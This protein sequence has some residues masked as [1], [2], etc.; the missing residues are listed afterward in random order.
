MKGRGERSSSVGGAS[1][2]LPDSERNYNSHDPLCTTAAARCARN[3]DP[4]LCGFCRI[5]GLSAL[6]PVHETPDRRSPEPQIWTR[7]SG[8]FRNVWTRA[9]EPGTI[10]GTKQESE[11]RT[12]SRSASTWS[13]SHWFWRIGSGGS[14]LQTSNPEKFRSASCD[15]SFK[16]S[17]NGRPAR[18]CRNPVGSVSS[19]TRSDD[20]I[21][22]EEYFPTAWCRHHRVSPRLCRSVGVLGDQTLGVVSQ[23]LMPSLEEP[24]RNQNLAAAVTD[25]CLYIRS[26]RR[27]R[28]SELEDRCRVTG[29]KSFKILHLRLTFHIWKKTETNDNSNLTVVFRPSQRFFERLPASCRRSLL[30]PVQVHRSTSWFKST[31]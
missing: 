27:S 25:G 30:F 23:T 12:F 29:W 6:R 15:A 28:T 1:A 2:L 9:K 31:Q 7:E 5:Y 22:D 14:G 11:K 8:L 20:I 3:G 17:F 26:C 21:Q 10:E 24:N 4:E 19:W 13:S 18:F 16:V